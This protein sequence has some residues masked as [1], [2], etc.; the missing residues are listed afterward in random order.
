MTIAVIR[1]DRKSDIRQRVRLSNPLS[2]CRNLQFCLRHF[3][4]FP[5]G[6]EKLFRRSIVGE[7][8]VKPPLAE[9]FVR[10]CVHIESPLWLQTQIN[11]VSTH[12]QEKSCGNISKSSVPSQMESSPS[13]SIMVA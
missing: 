2:I 8:F 5:Y 4:A 11:R 1:V 13:E 12:C 3:G 9:N 10:N 6:V 7:L